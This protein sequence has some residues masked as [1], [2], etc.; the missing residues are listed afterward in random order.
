MH[1]LRLFLNR[2]LRRSNAGIVADEPWRK[3]PKTSQNI[4]YK[5]SHECI[6]FLLN[7]TYLERVT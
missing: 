5:K 1:I 6:N 7:A 3:M 2:F 4:H